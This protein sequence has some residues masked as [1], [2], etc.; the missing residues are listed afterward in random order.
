MFKAFTVGVATVT[1]VVVAADIN[2]DSNVKIYG[3]Y[4][5]DHGY[6]LDKDKFHIYVEADSQDESERI[7]RVLSSESCEKRGRFFSILKIQNDQL[8]PPSVSIF[9]DKYSTEIQFTCTTTEKAKLEPSSIFVTTEDQDNSVRLARGL[10]ASH[11]KTEVR[12]YPSSRLI[13]T[14]DRFRCWY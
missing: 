13:V 5:D 12:I 14:F 10:A 7:A 1:P 8:A 6:W 3:N 2:K 9:D 11:A 4:N